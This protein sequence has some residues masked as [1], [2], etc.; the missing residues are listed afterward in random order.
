MYFGILHF[1]SIFVFVVIFALIEV[2]LFYKYDNKKTILTFSLLNF[3]VN[4]I[5]CFSVIMM[6]DEKSKIVTLKNVKTTRIYRTE[7]LQFQADL[8]NEGSMQVNKCTIS[9]RLINLAP[10]KVSGDIFDFGRDFEMFKID[11]SNP[12]LIKHEKTFIVNLLPQY[13]KRIV[14]NIKFPP[15]F[16]NYKT[17]TKVKCK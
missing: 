15:H 2:L 12:N 3:L 5:L 6:I 9:F 17:I 13:T 14:F 10:K 16:D 4:V 7:S 1:V 11:K 8:Y